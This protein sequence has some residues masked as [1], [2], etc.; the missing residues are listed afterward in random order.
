MDNYLSKWQRLI[1][2]SFSKK[3]MAVGEDSGLAKGRRPRSPVTTAQGR[4]AGAGEPQLQLAGERADGVAM[5]IG[6]RTDDVRRRG[7]LQNC[8]WKG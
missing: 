7:Y 6:N 3:A 5:A 2:R 1:S 8:D 4:P